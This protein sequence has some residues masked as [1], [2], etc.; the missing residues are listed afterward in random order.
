MSD[1]L[2]H[3]LNGDALAEVFPDDLSGRRIVFRE[4]LVEGPAEA[5]PLWEY[6][7][8][9]SEFLSFTY[10]QYDIPEYRSH[11]I[12]EIEKLRNLNNGESLNLWFEDDLFC[13]VNFWYLVYQ[14]ADRDLHLVRPT[15]PIEYGFGGMNQEDLV[16]GFL[17]R[18][19]LDEEMKDQL[20]CLWPAYASF[21]FA[22]LRRISV[23]LSE[24]LEFIR[25]VILA[26][27]ERQPDGD[28]PG[29]L[30]RRLKEI[31]QE[32]GTDQFGPVFRE[33]SRSEAVYGLGD[34]QVKRLF[35]IAVKNM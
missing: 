5:R 15:A 32:L 8:A 27:I 6:Y 34:L 20:S 26:H 11:V 17:Q 29:R 2:V 31:I 21:D 18:I 7:D 14:F 16:N 3:I 19:H 25:P 4:A 35:E 1:S 24:G 28:S 13:Q 23:G 10:G 22:Q 33:F 9:R 30:I 12:P